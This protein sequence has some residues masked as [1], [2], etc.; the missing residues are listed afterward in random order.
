MILVKHFWISI[1]NVMH[2]F[3]YKKIAKLWLNN[4][5]QMNIVQKKAA[6]I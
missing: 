2:I 6:S 1:P 4:F 5:L 3:N